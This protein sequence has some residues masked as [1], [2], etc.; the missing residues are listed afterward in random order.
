M[1]VLQW[2]DIVLLFVV[3]NLSEFLIWQGLLRL[4]TARRDIESEFWFGLIRNVICDSR[5]YLGEK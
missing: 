1:P 3:N 5:I 2:W 4:E